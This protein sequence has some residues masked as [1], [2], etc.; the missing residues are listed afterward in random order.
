MARPIVTD[1][2]DKADFIRRIAQAIYDGRARTGKPIT[3]IDAT[4][5]AR[6]VA[7]ALPALFVAG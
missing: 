2:I 6:Q 4:A 1:S 5:R 7:D 3:A